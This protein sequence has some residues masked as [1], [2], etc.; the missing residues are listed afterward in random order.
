MTDNSSTGEPW[1]FTPSEMSRAFLW[2]LLGG[3]LASAPIWVCAGI[4]FAEFV[5]HGH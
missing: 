1:V 2:G 4:H 5:S 3:A